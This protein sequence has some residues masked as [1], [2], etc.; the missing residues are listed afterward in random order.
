MKRRMRDLIVL[1]LALTPM[2]LHAQGISGAVVE[3]PQLILVSGVQMQLAAVA[4]DYQ[5]N[6]R[7]NDTF[8]FTSSNPAVI[9]V[10]ASGIVTARSPGIAGITATVQGTTFRTPAV[11]LQVIPL[12]IDVSAATPEITVGAAL[13]LNATALDVN[14]QPIP[15]VAFRWQV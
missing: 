1:I 5:G 10:D 6:P 14:G 2:T 12:R 11:Q 15:G 8:I 7:N 9:S 4:R 3:A 13:Q